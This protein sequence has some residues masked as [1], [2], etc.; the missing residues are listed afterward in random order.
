MKQTLYFVG[1][2]NSEAQNNWLVIASCLETAQAKLEELEEAT[3]VVAKEIDMR[4]RR[5]RKKK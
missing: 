2:D 3:V 1:H 5:R 4:R